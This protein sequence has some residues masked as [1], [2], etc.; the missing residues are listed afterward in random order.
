MFLQK[1]KHIK[2]FVLDIDGVLT[3]GTVQAT[4][5]GELLRTFNI[6]DG[7][8][9]QL[10]AKKGYKVCIISGAKGISVQKRFENLGVADVFLGISDK[11]PVFEAYLKQNNL[12]ASQVVY[13]GDDIPDRPVMQVVGIAA[14]P[15]DAVSE[16]KAVSIYVSP[17]AGGKGAVRDIIEK[18]LKAQENWFDFSPNA[19]DSS[20]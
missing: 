13:M 20:K 18:V 8:A 14:C 4:E 15:S 17:F 5:S 9:L 12:E 1:I 16:I 6:K 3:D 2:A 7:Y 19:A 10:L 11:L